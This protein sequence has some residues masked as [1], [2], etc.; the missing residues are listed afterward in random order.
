MTE[1]LTPNHGLSGA[2]GWIGSATVEDLLAA[3][4]EVVGLARSE[5]SAAALQ[6]RGVTVLRGDLDDLDSLRRGVADADGVVH[7]ANKHDWADPAGTDRTERL[8]VEAML[9]ALAGIHRPFITGL[10]AALVLPNCVGVLVHATAPERR[11]PVLAVWATAT[12]LGGIVGNIGG[13]ALLSAG[14]WRT[15]FAGVAV[16]GALSAL[17]AAFALPRSAR[18][19]HALDPAGRSCSSRR[20]SPCCWASSRARRPGG[21]ADR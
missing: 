13:G 8:A 14:S 12:G 19:D 7:L 6:A 21:R 20:S 9:E 5:S 15:L 2:S 16:L 4:H 10:G 18:S 1:S 11:R 17:W 3:D